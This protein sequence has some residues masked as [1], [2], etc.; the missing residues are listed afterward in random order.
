MSRFNMKKGIVG[1]LAQLAVSLCVYLTY[2]LMFYV[3]VDI[4]MVPAKERF[5][6]YHSFSVEVSLLNNEGSYL[7]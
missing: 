1:S 2:P 4:L 7:R 3:P 5:P 6:E